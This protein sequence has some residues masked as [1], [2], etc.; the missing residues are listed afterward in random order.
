MNQPKNKHMI[1]LMTCIPPGFANQRYIA[2]GNL[3][4]VK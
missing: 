1:T 2:V 3:I 4:E